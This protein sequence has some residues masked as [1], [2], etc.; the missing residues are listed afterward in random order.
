MVECDAIVALGLGLTADEL[1]TIYRTQFAVLY[2][3]DRNKRFYDAN[4]REVPNSVLTVWRRKG[5]SITEEEQ[6]AVHPGS[7]ITYTY[8]LPFITLDREADMRQAYAHFEQVLAK[9]QPD[10]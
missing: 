10:G 2:G 5:D 9:R 6:Q 1:C 4:G 7:G 8:E 3:Y